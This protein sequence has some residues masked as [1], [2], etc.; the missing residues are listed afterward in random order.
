MCTC[1]LHP[2]WSLSHCFACLRFCFP[3]S[4]CLNVFGQARPSAA[5]LCTYILDVRGLDPSIIL[6]SRGGTL[7]SIG[8]F[9]STNLSRHNL[10]REAGRAL[11]RWGRRAVRI[12]IA[13]QACIFDSSRGHVADCVR[14]VGTLQASVAGASVIAV[15][16]LGF[17]GRAR[18]ISLL[19]LLSLSLLLL[20]LSSLSLL[21][22]LL[23]L[24]L[25]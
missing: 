11:D 22:L 16:R 19:L 24:L 9:E 10:S 25:V 13:G 12:D 23:L 15:P 1:R 4:L 7:M 20:S 18:R 6:I 5:N 14:H 8:K 21:L 2:A 17:G 3:L